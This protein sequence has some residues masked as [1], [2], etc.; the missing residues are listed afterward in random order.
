M[1]IVHFIYMVKTN[2]YSTIYL[3]F[4]HINS[5]MPVGKLK[6]SSYPWNWSAHHP[7]CTAGNG[8]WERV[9]VVWELDAVKVPDV[10]QKGPMGRTD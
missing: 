7:E 1:Y 10:R 6:E 9:A 8:E 5:V 2:I 4:L 3:I